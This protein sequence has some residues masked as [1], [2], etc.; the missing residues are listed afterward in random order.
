MKYVGIALWLILLPLL[1]ALLR[2][3]PHRRHWA[4]MAIGALLLFAGWHFEAAIIGWPIWNGTVKGTEISPL[5]ALALALIV[6]R[7]RSVGWP[8]LWSL[9][10]L[11]GAVLAFSV[12]ISQV[13][14]ASFFSFWQFLRIALLFVAVAGEGDQPIVRRAL[15]SG[16]SLGLLMQL[17]YVV[18]QKAHGVVQASGTAAHQNMLG[19]MV[20]LSMLPL[21]GA[22]L[23]GSRSKLHYTGIAASLLI[24]AAGGSRATIGIAGGGVVILV[25]LSVIRQS[26]PR[27]MTIIGAGVLALGVAVPVGLATLKDR[28]GSS[29]M[30]AEDT[31]R[32][33]FERSAR[34]MAADY[35]FGVGANLYVSIANTKGY[36]QR[37]GVAW[38]FANR[39]APVHNAYLLAR[40]ETG[41]IGESVFILFLVVA[42]IRGLIMAFSK[43][44]GAMGEVALA[45]S[46]ALICN[47]IHNNYEFASHT[48]FVLGLLAI[49]MGLISASIRTVRR[50][51]QARRPAPRQGQPIPSR[52]V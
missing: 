6:T 7:R 4:Y 21:V 34:A 28:F 25:L 30:I 1:V 13:P 14:M 29:T 8:P 38:N 20:A 27:K 35:P 3:N 52:P 39:S 22:I 31:Q 44:S 37:A 5:D 11:Y 2:Q 23:A 24:I 17:F 49:N 18:L 42:L 40:A 45:S 15:L 51:K 41:W 10:A 48:Y 19:M 36:A 9:F 43:R 50:P 46:I 32:L 12:V 47:V 16:L 26:T 33:A